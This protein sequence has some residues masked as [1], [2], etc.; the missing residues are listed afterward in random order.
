MLYK[1]YIRTYI[2]YAKTDIRA[3]RNAFKVQ[4]M[5]NIQLYTMDTT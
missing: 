2:L 4:Y 3:T 1:I 5:Y